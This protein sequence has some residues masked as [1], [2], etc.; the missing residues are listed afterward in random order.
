[1]QH[2]NLESITKTKKESY[3]DY[4]ERVSKNNYAIQVKIVD[5]EHNMD[6]TR[7]NAT[8]T[9]TDI[10]RIVKYQKAYLYLLNKQHV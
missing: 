7:L 2:S 8:L 3:S 10:E 5:L 4:I 9:P 1:M 6:I